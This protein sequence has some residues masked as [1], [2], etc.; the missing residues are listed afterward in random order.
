MLMN[1]ESC[2]KC[3]SSHWMDKD[4]VK[5]FCVRHEFHPMKH[6]HCEQFERDKNDEK[7]ILTPNFIRVL[8]ILRSI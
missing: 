4:K 8:A 3:G 1:G 7:L 2:L 5:L 6:D